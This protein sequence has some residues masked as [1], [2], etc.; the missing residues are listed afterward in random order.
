MVLGLKDSLTLRQA[1]FMHARW[2]VDI[3]MMY[4][5][6]W[7]ELLSNRTGLASAPTHAYW[8]RS[9]QR[10]DNWQESLL[11]HRLKIDSVGA[12]KRVALWQSIRPTLEEIFLSDMLTRILATTTRTMERLGI[13][14]EAS[15]IAH[16]VFTAHEDV[17]NRC[18]RLMMLPGLPVD[19]S[20]ELN[21]IRHSLEHWT[22]R[23][24]ASLATATE[25]TSDKTE[26]IT[27]ATKYAFRP[28]L[29]SEFI[30]EKR[31]GEIN[32]AN[33]DLLVPACDPMKES[34]E[35]HSQTTE[36]LEVRLLSTSC[37]RWISTHCRSV[38]AN[39]TDNR[40]IGEAA[41]AIVRP[42]NLQDW[43]PLSG[44]SVDRISSLIEQ[45]EQWLNQLLIP[46]R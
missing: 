10:F 9:R 13:D 27:E 45:A 5:R 21:R 46:S 44:G 17:R 31:G 2:L 33:R 3:A 43:S 24:L 22:D 30:E 40:L 34:I 28:E 23:F 12:S 20:V 39:P 35:L 38:S 19:Q 37:E 1:A 15:P 14:E 42:E 36:S 32:L 8:T 25:L 29:V 6:Q 7:P 18:L 4:V 41:L 26:T 11:Q 16:S